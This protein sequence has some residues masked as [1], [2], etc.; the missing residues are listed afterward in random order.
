M[1][2]RIAGSE[3][4]GLN[5]A[6]MIWVYIDIGVPPFFIFSNIPKLMTNRFWVV[7][8]THRSRRQKADP[9]ACPWERALALSRNRWFW[10]RPQSVGPTLQER[11]GQ[12]WCQGGPEGAAKLL[13]RPHHP[14]SLL[15]FFSKKWDKL[16]DQ[17]NEQFISEG[18]PKLG[19]A[20]TS[21][22][23]LLSRC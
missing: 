13:G 3:F 17:G 8:S 16:C 19:M 11:Y 21:L 5:Q 7:G 18:F 20:A 6:D 9:L 4:P 1:D 23:L 2:L 22:S 10:K 12:E 15:G 14:A